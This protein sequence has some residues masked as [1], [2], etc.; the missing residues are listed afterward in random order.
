MRKITLLIFAIYS[1]VLG[2]EFY[3]GENLIAPYQPEEDNWEVVTKKDSN[4][5]S[6]MWRDKKLG[7]SNSYVVSIYQNA[8]E[9]LSDFRDIQDKPGKK[10]CK[11]F[12]SID[13]KSLT[14]QKYKSNY[15]RTNCETSGGYKAQMIHL[16]IQGKDS[17]YHIQRI[18]RG[19]EAVPKVETWVARISQIY[20]CDTRI[21][22]NAC[23]TEYLKVRDM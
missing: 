5:R 1:T 13:L 21:K 20:V 3:E 19:A 11:L 8:Q 9:N 6:M 4:M 16:V 15:W 17:L 7:F 22:D 14:N 23:P 2:S 12:E 10:A 18:W